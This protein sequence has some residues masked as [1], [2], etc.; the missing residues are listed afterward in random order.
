MIFSSLSA[1]GVSHV[2]VNCFTLASPGTNV[3]LKAFASVP[4]F[5]V[6]VKQSMHAGSAPVALNVTVPV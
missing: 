2:T 6:T 4:L 5:G 3:Y 1:P